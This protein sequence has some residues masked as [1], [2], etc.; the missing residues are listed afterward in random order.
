MPK[1]QPYFSI[2]MRIGTSLAVQRVR[3]HASTEGGIGSTSSLKWRSH[4]PCNEGK[5]KKKTDNNKGEDK[6]DLSK[7]VNKFPSLWCVKGL[8]LHPSCKLSATIFVGIN[9]RC[10][11]QRQRALFFLHSKQ[12]RQRIISG[13]LAPSPMDRP[14]WTTA[15]TAG[16]SQERNP[17]F[18]EPNF[19]V[20]RKHLPFSLSFPGL[21]T[22]ILE[23]RF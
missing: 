17:E 16:V 5:K 18:R 14:G 21:F 23:D 3:N 8:R 6:F 12:Q 2:R 22:S 10:P 9:M 7:K 20:G 11:G 13:T 1:Q 15:S 19:Y 4:M